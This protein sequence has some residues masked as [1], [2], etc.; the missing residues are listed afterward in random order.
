MNV[1][2]EMIDQRF[3]A[4]E[5]RFDGKLDSL[6]GRIYE[7]MAKQSRATVFAFLGSALTFASLV[8]AARLI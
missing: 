1:R 8:F 7:R 3:D 4:M 2:F 6:E 5:A